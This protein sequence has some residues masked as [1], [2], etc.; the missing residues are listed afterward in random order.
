MPRVA[1]SPPQVCETDD[2]DAG[3]MCWTMC[4]SVAHLACGPARAVCVDLTM[5]EVVDGEEHCPS[6]PMD[7]SCAPRCVWPGADNA[8]VRRRSRLSGFGFVDLFDVRIR[9]AC[10][11]EE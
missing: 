9:L 10:R 4:V 3:V 6:A 7:S 8:T 2:G 5:G 1:S 11:L